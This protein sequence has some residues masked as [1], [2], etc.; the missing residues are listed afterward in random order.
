MNQL[1]VEFDWV[2][3]TLFPHREEGEIQCWEADDLNARATTDFQPWRKRIWI[4]EKEIG[5]PIVTLCEEQFRVPQDHC[6]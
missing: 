6:Q 5:K 1:E 3:K 2:R 4:S